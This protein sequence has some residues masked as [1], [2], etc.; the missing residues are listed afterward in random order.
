MKICITGTAGFIGYH[1]AVK[2]LN[3]GHEVYGIDNIN[4]YYDINL[5]HGRLKELGIDVEDI[6]YSK[7]IDSFN[8]D[9]FK[10]YK[11][12]LE[13]Q[14][15][16][17]AFFK[18]YEIDAICNLAAQAG[19]RYSLSNPRSYIRS[20]IDGFMNI[21]EICRNLNI[22]NLS[23][24]SSSSVY[25]LNS[26]YPFNPSK[27]VD[28]P[29]SLY[30]ASKRAN[31][32][33][34]HTYSHLFKI[35]TTGL[36]FFTVYGPWGRPDMALFLFTQA[37]LDGKAIKIFNNGQ[38][39][40][41]FTYIDDIVDGVYKVINNPANENRE[42]DS[43]KP[44]SDSSSAPFLIYNIGNDENVK[45]MD[46]IASLENKL[47]VTIKKEMLPL[48]AGDVP[49]TFAD[50]S[51]IVNDLDYNPST[52]YEVGISHFVDWYKSFYNQ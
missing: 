49:D 32:L 1:V 6:E 13:D 5:K 12:D 2:C 41:C 20:N 31:E 51:K 19:V 9:N 27:P 8:F 16:L 25:G 34:A 44:N 39:S 52:S 7:T 26:N 47:G 42:W 46:F 23:Y 3:E 15:N 45:L 17:E 36:R 18:K 4:N 21:L 30:A 43:Y 35:K 33:M 38:M 50:I 40:R 37:A 24:A 29:I 48:Q 22:S 11:C 28:H 14:E 10:F